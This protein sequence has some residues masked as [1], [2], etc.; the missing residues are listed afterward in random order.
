MDQS[1][2]HVQIPE[3]DREKAGDAGVQHS[4]SSFTS[5]YCPDDVHETTEN[6]S[7][8][9]QS[10][11]GSEQPAFPHWK[12]ACRP[13]PRLDYR[14]DSVEIHRK[15]AASEPVVIRH[16]D[17]VLKAVGHWDFWQLYEL[18]GSKPE[19]NNTFTVHTSRTG[20]FMYSD[21]GQNTA[22]YVLL[23]EYMT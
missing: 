1:E 18:L 10:T 16:F 3:S 15:L 12:K 2:A 9:S 7:H 21:E 4:R 11:I 20:K 22:G 19:F 23:L 8:V 17:P 6:G 5:S 13:I 14:K